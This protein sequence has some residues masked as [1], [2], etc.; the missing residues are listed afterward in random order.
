VCA[1]RKLEFI[2]CSAIGLTLAVTRAWLTRRN[3][4]AADCVRVYHETRLSSMNI[5]RLYGTKR[6]VWEHAFLGLNDSDFGESA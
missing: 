6:E 4:L 3:A 2:D 5:I 1:T